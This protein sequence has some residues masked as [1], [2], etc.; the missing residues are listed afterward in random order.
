MSKKEEFSQETIDYI[1][2]LALLELT[3]AEKKDLSTQLNDIISYFH[4]LDDLDTSNVPPTRHPLENIKNV[5]R[6]DIPTEGLSN[7]E[8]LQNA[9]HKKEGF[10]KAPKI[11]KD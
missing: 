1:S 2:K 11:L 10:F 7:E 6:N 3:D 4:K 5:Y 8:A 9:P